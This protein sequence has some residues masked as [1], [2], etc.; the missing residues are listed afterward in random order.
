MNY[1]PISNVNRSRML[2]TADWVRVV[3][4]PAASEAF[5]NL[6][7]KLGPGEV[8]AISVALSRSADW[9]LVDDNLARIA[10]IELGIPVIGTF[11]ILKQAKRRGYVTAVAPLVKAMRDWGVW[12][13]HELERE[14]LADVGEEPHRT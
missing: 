14:F 5:A 8:A 12:V 6:P 1:M 10:A 4:P 3:E 2:A 9:L 11:G 7:D 13:T